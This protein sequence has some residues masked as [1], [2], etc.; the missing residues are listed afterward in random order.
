MEID[1][2]DFEHLLNQ[3][4]TP[5]APVHKAV[6]YAIR[7]HQSRKQIGGTF[8][9]FLDSQVWSSAPTVALNLTAL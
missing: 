4:N 1:G 7:N 6:D 2:S 3:F 9:K 8:L 5:E